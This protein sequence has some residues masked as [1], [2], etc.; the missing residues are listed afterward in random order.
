MKAFLGLGSNMGDR[1]GTLQR[2]VELLM[3]TDGITVVRSSRVYETSAAG[4]PQGQPDFLN[5][6]I[7]VE[8]TLDAHALLKA[9]LGIEDELG[10]VRTEH[11]GPR[12]ADI[13]VLTYGK[14]EIVDDEITVPHPHMH[15]RMFV[16]APLLELDADPMLPGGRK[17][18]TLNL[19]QGAE[20]F[21]VRLFAPP[22]EIPSP[23]RGAT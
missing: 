9:C 2:M 10:R 12:T 7:G 1:L 20:P 8:T 4:G 6:A 23:P 22:L 16:L 21:G 3:A 18:A 14:E 15:E 13:D 19:E 5:A 11:W 17:V